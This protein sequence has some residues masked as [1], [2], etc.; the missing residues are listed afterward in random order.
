MPKYAVEMRPITKIGQTAELCDLSDTQHT[1]HARVYV[2][3]CIRVRARRV[4]VCVCG[5]G[6]LRRFD[7]CYRPTTC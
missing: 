6:G 2:C 7:M 1:A 4:C 3:V 5:G